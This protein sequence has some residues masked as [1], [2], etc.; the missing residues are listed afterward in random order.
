VDIST[1]QIAIFSKYIDTLVYAALLQ[2]HQPGRHA[3][4]T[5]IIHLKN[6]EVFAKQARIDAQAAV[7][8]RR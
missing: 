8:G 2:F 7:E 1:H 5:T 6:V 3:M 4:R